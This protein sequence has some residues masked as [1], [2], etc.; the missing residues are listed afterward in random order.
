MA[1]TNISVDEETKN[2]IQYL[3]SIYKIETGVFSV[4][5]EAATIKAIGELYDIKFKK[6]GKQDSTLPI[7]RI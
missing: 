6:Y 4:T 7:T 3:R 5:Q 2:K 1:R